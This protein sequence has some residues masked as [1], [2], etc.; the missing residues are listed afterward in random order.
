M[1]IIEKYPIGAIVVVPHPFTGELDEAEVVNHYDG[2]PSPGSPARHILGIVVRHS[3]DGIT[4]WIDGAYLDEDGGD[5]DEETV[6]LTEAASLY[7]L[8]YSTLAQA[9][10]EGRIEARQSGPK[11]WI[12]TRAAIEYAIANGKLRPRD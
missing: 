10:R 8:A 4:Q 2:P 1:W 3:A 7:P 12:T 11:T 5:R 9:A 6:T